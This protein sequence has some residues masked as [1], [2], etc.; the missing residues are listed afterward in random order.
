MSRHWLNF[1]YEWK[2]RGGRKETNR[3]TNGSITGNWSCFKN[4]AN[5][6]NG[7]TCIRFLPFRLVEILFIST[8][9]C[10]R[11]FIQSCTSFETIFLLVNITEFFFFSHCVSS[12]PALSPPASLWV[13]FLSNRVCAE[14]GWLFPQTS[15]VLLSLS[16]CRRIASS[17]CIITTTN[18]T[19]S[20]YRHYQS[21]RTK[22]DRGPI[23]SLPPGNSLFSR[24]IEY[25]RTRREEKSQIS[26]FF[27][28]PSLF[29]PEKEFFVS[30]FPL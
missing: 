10:H 21:K 18:R 24:S 6:I 9:Y 28:S 3:E 17:H 19:S 15:E 20:Y 22:A 30:R 13:A 11:L 26:P 23:S 27:L 12:A 25:P 29:F 4:Q 14:H 1:Y 5:D 16:L 7:M 8:T 2:T